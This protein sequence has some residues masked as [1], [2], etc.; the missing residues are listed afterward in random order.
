MSYLPNFQLS[1]FLRRAIH[2]FN[3]PQFSPRL[4]FYFLL[5]RD[6]SCHEEIFTQ[7]RLGP[8]IAILFVY[9]LLRSA[10]ALRRSEISGLS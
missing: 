3:S 9:V 2:A 5:S 6:K 8:V 1:T 4:E 10:F 7:L